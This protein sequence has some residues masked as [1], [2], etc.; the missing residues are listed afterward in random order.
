MDLVAEKLQEYLDKTPQKQKEKDCKE[1]EQC[2]SIS[3]TVD[4]Y[5]KSIQGYENT[6]NNR[7]I[8]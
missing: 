2:S 5:I 7:T 6:T 1:L 4:E 3:P 8:K